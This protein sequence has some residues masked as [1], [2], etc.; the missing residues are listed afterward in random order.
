MIKLDLILAA[1]LLVS[2]VAL[3]KARDESRLLFVEQDQLS[4]QARELN[5]QWSQLKL[6]QSTL[7]AQARVEH[8]ARAQLG[9]VNLADNQVLL[10][11]Y[12]AQQP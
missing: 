6:Q 10:M 3:V 8:I 7:A 4:R 12:G 2:A 5:L 1:L 11:S 9:L